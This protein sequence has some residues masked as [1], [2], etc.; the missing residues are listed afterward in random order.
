MKKRILYL[1]IEAVALSFLFL[2]QV[3]AEEGIN[4]I[5]ERPMT[6]A[7]IAS[8]KEMEPELYDNFIEDFN[9]L[10]SDIQTFDYLP[11]HYDSREQGIVS[12][13]KN[14]GNWGCCWAV[15][16]VDA[17][18]IN[19]ASQNMQ[20]NTDYSEGHLAYFFYNRVN[21]PLNNTDGD[22]NILPNGGHYLKNGG[23]TMLAAQSLATWSG[24]ADESVMPFEP[25]TELITPD[26]DASYNDNAILK[27]AMYLSDSIY[28]IKNAICQYGAVSIN[29]YHDDNY[30]NYNTAAYCNPVDR[31]SNHAVV[32]VGWDDNYAKENFLANGNVLDN[33]AWI[34]KNSWS[35]A[36]GDNGYFYLSYENIS[37]NNG[38]VFEVQPTDT[39]DHNYQYDGTGGGG[40][41]SIRNQEKISNIY[42]VKGNNRGGQECLKAIGITLFDSNIDYAVQIYRNLSDLSD[43]ESGEK[44]LENP[45]TG[46]TQTAGIKTIE[47]ENE[48]Y[49]NQGETYSVVIQMN[50]SQSNSV[51]IGVEGNSDYGWVAFLAGLEKEESYI[52]RNSKWIDLYNSALCA[53]IKAFTDDV[54]VEVESIKLSQ[55]EVI[56]NKGEEVELTA[57]IFPQNDN[58]HITWASD[59]QN[60]AQTENGVISAVG[61]G[62]CI[63]TAK[64]GDKTAICNVK[65]KPESPSLLEV[66][67]MDQNRISITWKKCEGVDGYMIYRQ[68]PERK[69]MI[70]YKNILS[71]NQT[72][73]IDMGLKSGEYYFYRVYS[74]FTASEGEKILS[75]SKG[76]KYAKPILPAVSGLKAECAGKNRV[77]LSWKGIAGAEGY[78]LYRQVGKGKFVYKGMTKAEKYLDTTASAEEY[79]FYR[80]CPYFT[81]DGAKIPG[82]TNK[83]VFAKGITAAV[84]NLRASKVQAGIKLTWEKSPTAEGYLIYAQKNGKYGYCGMTTRGTTYIDKK[85]LKNMYN[86]YWIFPYHMNESGKMIVGQTGK[87]VAGT[88]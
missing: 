21:D 63:I 39:Y 67:S 11:Q 9:F 57:D 62:K 82:A 85:A 71:N 54:D 59:N 14:Q 55:N 36:W 42:H 8:Q 58:I 38:I 52:Y 53:R 17:A 24:F 75:D 13:V 29:Y 76:Y 34:V 60:V 20:C 69:Q 48:I 28:E 72:S 6:E 45:V 7:E 65:V 32:L 12:D 1:C 25:Y 22:K 78:L 4:Y 33:G 46:R 88:L 77:N 80:I 73:F 43:P 79:N 86:F 3:N 15:S 61:P 47:L 18:G 19:A 35:Q 70:H 87:Y 50:N 40:Y 66:K 27:N 30:Y 37:T 49:L 56:L 26:S 83:Y 10:P 41:T 2:Q 74:Y 31:G 68:G 44:V 51:R 84:K 81:K 5:K 64:A 16:A 23:N